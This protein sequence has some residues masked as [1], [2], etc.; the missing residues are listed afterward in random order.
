MTKKL[1]NL[2]IVPTGKH[3]CMMHTY[4]DVGGDVAEKRCTPFL[5]S[6]VV[7][8]WLVSMQ[9][10]VVKVGVARAV[11]DWPALQVPLHR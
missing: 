4:I 10:C 2:R 5:I 11:A 6:L 7:V 9:R 1:H 8:R 3:P